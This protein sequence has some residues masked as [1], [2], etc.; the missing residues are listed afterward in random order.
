LAEAGETGLMNLAC[1]EAV[2]KAELIE[3]LALYSGISSQHMKR[4]LTPKPE[5]GQLQRANAMGL[6]CTKAQSRLFAIGHSLP[7]ANEVVQALVKSF[8]E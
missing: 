1:S 7:N 6:D 5:L 3:K 4:V 8:S 2:S